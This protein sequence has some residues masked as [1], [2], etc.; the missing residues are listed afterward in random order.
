MNSDSCDGLGLGATGRAVTL[1]WLG[2]RRA[3]LTD[4]NRLPID[5]RRDW[6]VPGRE[7]EMGDC[8]TTPLSRMSEIVPARLSGREGGGLGLWTGTDV[9]KDLRLSMRL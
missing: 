4:A 5:P 7:V 1:L 2:T 3:V 9:I 8:V 6:D